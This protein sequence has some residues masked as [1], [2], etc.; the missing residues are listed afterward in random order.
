MF[1]LS[2]ATFS[3]CLKRFVLLDEKLQCVP[4][5]PHKNTHTIHNTPTR[6]TL[7]TEHNVHNK[8]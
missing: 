7:L 8:T 6:S 5:R 4:A 2:D 3:L 1:H